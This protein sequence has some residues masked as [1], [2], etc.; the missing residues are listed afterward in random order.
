MTRVDARE[1]DGNGAGLGLFPLVTVFEQVKTVR[2]RQRWFGQLNG[3]WAG[4]FGIAVQGYEIH[5]GLTFLR[6]DMVAEGDRTSMV[7]P[8]AMAWEN[9]AGNVL[10]IYLHGMFEDAR[11]FASAVWHHCA[12]AWQRV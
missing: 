6:A 7:M 4:L 10:G 2:H 8:D 1:I 5:H 3:P 12:H 11:A 9:A